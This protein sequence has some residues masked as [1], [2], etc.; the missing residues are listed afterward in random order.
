VTAQSEGW[1]VFTVDLVSTP[2]IAMN[3]LGRVGAQASLLVSRSNL[4]FG[5]VLANG[6]TESQHETVVVTNTGELTTTGNVIAT[7]SNTTAGVATSG[8]GSTLPYLGT[9]TMT[10]WVVPQAAGPAVAC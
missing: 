10:I 4:D 3:L 9:C 5:Y 1:R 7:L 8:C 6:S 2:I